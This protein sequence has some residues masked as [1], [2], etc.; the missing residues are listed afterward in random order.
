MIRSLNGSDSEAKRSD[1]LA[2]LI[3]ESS[4]SKPKRT[5][6][7]HRTSGMPPP[8]RTPQ[9][10]PHKSHKG[11]SKKQQEKGPKASSSN[12]VHPP[13]EKPLPA[14]PSIL[15]PRY[16]PFTSTPLPPPSMPKKRFLRRVLPFLLA[17]TAGAYYYKDGMLKKEA[18]EKI[19]DNTVEVSSALV[20]ST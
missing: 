1:P 7:K 17:A 18:A 14:P 4:S 6:R 19:E 9:F 2:A 13:P 20:E 12:P 10:A 5:T 8:S 15:F 3:A 16:S 11:K